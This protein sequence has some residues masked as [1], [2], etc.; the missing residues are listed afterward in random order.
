MTRKQFRCS[1]TRTHRRSESGANHA[2]PARVA[3]ATSG[4][5]HA[6]PVGLASPPTTTKFESA[7]PFTQAFTSVSTITRRHSRI[8]CC[9]VRSWPSACRPGWSCCNRSNKC[10]AV[11]SGS[12]EAEESL[13]G[14]T[15]AS[16]MSCMYN[17]R[18]AISRLSCRSGCVPNQPV[19][20]IEPNCMT[21]RRHGVPTEGAAPQWLTIDA[22]QTLPNSSRSRAPVSTSKR[23]CPNASAGSSLSSAH[24]WEWHP[25]VARFIAAPNLLSQP[26]SEESFRVPLASKM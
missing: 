15:C 3:A 26:L 12:P 17:T 16:R 25:H 11:T 8:R 14:L 10:L 21:E 19:C 13:P 22:P 23:S 24:C 7:V 4:R 6:D 20:G 5:P 2:C 18:L 9:N 1:T